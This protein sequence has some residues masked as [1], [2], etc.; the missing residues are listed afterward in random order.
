MIFTPF[1]K[2]IL[3]EQCLFITVDYSFLRVVVKGYINIEQNGLPQS[4]FPVLTVKGRYAYPC[5]KAFLRDPIPF[6]A[7]H[8]ARRNGFLYRKKRDL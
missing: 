1:L 7:L 6:K 5:L 4:G 8:W 3:T 2:G